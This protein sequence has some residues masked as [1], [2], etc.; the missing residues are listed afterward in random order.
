MNYMNTIESVRAEHV[1]VKGTKD[2]IAVIVETPLSETKIN[3]G[4]QFWTPAMIQTGTA[5]NSDRSISTFVDYLER[6]RH[7]DN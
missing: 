7:V 6:P 1:G 3:L 2:R 5:Q 4:V